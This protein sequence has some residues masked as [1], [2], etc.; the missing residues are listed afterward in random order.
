MR[1]MKAG[2]F[3]PEK[4]RF[5]V[6][7]QPKLDG[8]RL[9]VM[10]GQSYTSRMK[11]YPN[12]FIRDFWSQQQTQPGQLD[13]FDGLDGEMT[14][15]EFTDTSSAGLG[16]HSLP[17]FKYH[18]FDLWNQETGF[19]ARW[20]CAANR[21]S[22]LNHPRVKIVPIRLLHSMEEL[23]EYEESQIVLGYEGIILR[24]PNGYYKQGRSTA[25]EGYCIKVKRFEDSECEIVDF[26]C[27]RSNQNEKGV[28]ELGLTKRSSHQAGMVEMDTLGKLIVR[29]CNPES[30]YYGVEFKVGSFRGLTL[31]DRK[32]IWDNQDEFRHKI[33]TYKYQAVGG[34][35]KPR[36]P[37]FKR[38]RMELL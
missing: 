7:G 1:P 25:N 5:P 12:L 32:H 37:I 11:L 34:Y 14:S 33:F 23:L 21:I 28:N 9:L 31:P 6:I 20:S 35:E 16:H 27:L 22:G 3:V 4:I 19:M 10:N 36:I 15:A 29:D 24:D 17:D 13:G 18:V 38:W 26:E 30:P 8:W 2:P